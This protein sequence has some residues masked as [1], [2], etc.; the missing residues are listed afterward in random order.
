MQ[1]YQNTIEKLFDGNRQHIKQTEQ[2]LQEINSNL[3]QSHTKFEQEMEQVRQNR[4]QVQQIFQQIQQERQ[5][6][7]QKFEQSFNETKKMKEKYENELKN[8]EKFICQAKTKLE[9]L[10]K[11]SNMFSSEN[12]IKRQQN[13]A[14]YEKS[15]KDL[16]SAIKIRIEQW[17]PEDLEKLQTKNDLLI[18][19]L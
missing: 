13:C 12:F 3:T 2:S 1:Y 17:T 8:L 15:L 14:H 7:S 16:E 9:K 11:I 10:D 6:Q 5:Q 18:S 19:M 4:Q